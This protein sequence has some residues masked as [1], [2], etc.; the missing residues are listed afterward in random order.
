MRA[1]GAAVR[2]SPPLLACDRVDAQAHPL[3]L[4]SLGVG[5]PLLAA[6][7][8]AL[9]EAVNGRVSLVDLGV[10]ALDAE[11]FEERREHRA[12]RFACEAAPLVLGRQRHTDLGARPLGVLDPDRAVPAQLCGLAVDCGQLHPLA[13]PTELGRLLLGHDW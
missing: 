1:L 13:G 12:E 9:E 3:A 11:P 4:A 10:D 8:E 6:Q 5:N 7:A 2:F